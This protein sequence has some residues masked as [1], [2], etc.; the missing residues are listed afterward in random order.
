M[1]L[2]LA[3]LQAR[4][5]TLTGGKGGALAELIANDLPVPPGF[6]IT[7]QAFEDFIATNSMAD[8]IKGFFEKA[9]LADIDDLAGLTEPLC[10]KIRSLSMPDQLLEGIKKRIEEIDGA[11]LWAVRS[12]AVAEDLED[13]SFAGQYDT[14]LGLTGVSEVADA[15][16]SCWASFFN[17]H[18]IKYKHERGIID[19]HG[20]VVVQSLVSADSAG[21]CFTLDPLTGDRDRVVIN[22]NFGLGESVVSGLVTPDTLTV[23]KSN[24]QV[25]ARNVATK[26]IKTV[27]APGGSTEVAVEDTSKNLASLTDD[28]AIKIC[29][30]AITIE[31]QTGRPVDIE[32]AV[33]GDDVYILQSRPVT[34]GMEPI[35]EEPPPGWVPELNTPIDPEYPLYSNGNISEVLPGCITPLSWSYIAPTI[36][37]AFRNQGIEL[38][39]MTNRGPEY[40]VLGFFFHRPYICVSFME[41]AALRTPGMSP[42]TIHEEFVGP[43]ETT[44][45]PMTLRDLMPDR[46]PAIYRIVSTFIKKT[47]TVGSDVIECERLIKIQQQESTPEKLQKWPDEQLIDAVKFTREMSKLSNVHIW[48]SSFAVVYFG[49]LRKLSDLWLCDKNGS[50]A[51]Q[52]VTGIGAL[53]SADPAFGLYQLARHA[54]KAKAILKIF[55]ETSDNQALLDRLSSSDEAFEFRAAFEAFLADYGH[56][57][58]CEAEFRNPCWREDPAQVIGLIRNFMAPGLTPP[59]E[60]RE[61]Q[62][63]IRTESAASIKALVLPKRV[64]LNRVLRAARHNIEL[65]EKLKDLIVLRSDRARRVYSEIRSR[66]VTRGLI[67][68]PD[69]IYFLIGSEVRELI[70]GKISPDAALKIVERRGREFSW[71]QSLSLP[72]IIEGEAKPLTDDDFSAD[73][74]LQGMG[75][76]PG[77]VEGTARVILDPRRES[78]IKPGEILVA[79]VTD[80]GWTPLFIN[81]AGLVVDVGG[82]L[83]HGSVVAREYGLPAVVGVT[84][85]TKRIKSGDRIRINGSS[86]VVGILQ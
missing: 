57:A 6:V 69:D 7:T 45:S 52:L 30:L 1:F 55:V 15:V 12:S 60:I 31:Q 9:A 74:Q 21:V 38:G 40:Q 49:L 73:S 59:E 3:D 75:V 65:R 79:P 10:D 20:A 24:L 16:L 23:Q 82:L 26:E 85:A 58:V 29:E 39:S 17:A 32:W 41:A 48:A 35:V 22:A 86:G 13:A 5:V 78:H 14:I 50:I 70:E 66:L 34:A 44:T 84:G 72:K 37:H 80:A 28:Q 27:P 76:S 4:D 36:E 68:N 54:L 33:R 63:R 46:W 77:L 2:N 61:R 71:S 47:R 42:D 67:E 56:R 53:P 18:A 19:F 11:A 62:N 83:S 51:A 64:L 8:E 43:P 25:L 81:A